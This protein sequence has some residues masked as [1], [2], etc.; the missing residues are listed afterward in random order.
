MQ[1]NAASFPD[2]R[3]E[4][5]TAHEIVELYR[6]ICSPRRYFGIEHEL[7]EIEYELGFGES[8]S[9]SRRIIAL[10]EQSPSASQI[11]T[12]YRPGVVI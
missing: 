10:V 11:T 1:N 9:R 7:G 2:L 8:T 6:N 12:Q 3:T 5:R 4:P